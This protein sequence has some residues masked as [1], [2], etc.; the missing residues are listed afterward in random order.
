M[1]VLR[2]FSL[3]NTLKNI[4]KQFKIE[5]L[6]CFIGQGKKILVDI[7]TENTK[8]TPD[9]LR[10]LHTSI[11]K[12]Y[13]LQPSVFSRIN[14]LSSYQIAEIERKYRLKFYKY[15]GVTID[16]QE[17]YGFVHKERIPDY[18]LDFLKKY[19]SN[20]KN[21][22]E[23]L[24]FSPKYDFNELD[25][26]DEKL[27]REFVKKIHKKCMDVFG[28]N[29][30]TSK[31]HKSKNVQKT[32]ILVL[33]SGKVLHSSL[34][35]LDN[36]LV[37]FISISGEKAVGAIL[38]QKSVN[39]LKQEYNFKEVY[40]NFT[41]PNTKTDLVKNKGYGVFSAIQIPESKLI[42]ECLNY[43][44]ELMVDSTNG[45]KFMKPVSTLRINF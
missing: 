10:I 2:E 45:D 27:R 7:D 34:Q 17:K 12:D 35:Y 4:L 6:E 15:L 31:F 14:N 28:Y 44:I 16:E 30:F 41:L 20:L 18:E 42:Y 9:V 25:A 13:E 23:L 29:P 21:K 32:G 11:S 37:Y 8:Y 1:R 40:G 43:G 39:Y 19:L 38:L 22:R 36:K 26:L 3:E 24:P 33:H 5:N